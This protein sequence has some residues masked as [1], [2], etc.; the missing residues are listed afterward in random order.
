MAIYGLS[1]PKCGTCA[2]GMF[3]STMN[4]DYITITADFKE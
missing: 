3:D 2:I 1:D 4:D